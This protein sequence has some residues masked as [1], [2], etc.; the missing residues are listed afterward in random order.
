MVSRGVRVPDGTSVTLVA[1]FP[2]DAGTRTVRSATLL[3]GGGALVL[4]IALLAA[5]SQLLTS[6]LAPVQRITDEV[7]TISQSG[8]GDRVTVPAARDEI[9]RSREHTHH[10]SCC[11]NGT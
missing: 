4:S 8:S 3:F 6:A 1:A 2:L 10:H 7:A 11:L 5:L 9:T